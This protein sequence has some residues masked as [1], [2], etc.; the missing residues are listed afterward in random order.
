M[1]AADSTRI[2]FLLRRQTK[3]DARDG[4]STYHTV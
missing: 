4:I 1:A 2:G 3:L